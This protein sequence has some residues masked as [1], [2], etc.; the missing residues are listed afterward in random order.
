MQIKV[1]DFDQALG[2]SKI[3]LVLIGLIEQWILMRPVFQTIDLG[4][5]DRRA[6]SKHPIELDVIKWR[7]CLKVDI[8]FG[9]RIN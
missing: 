7:L 1:V 6:V 8:K 4:A 3:F 9:N 5:L 2:C